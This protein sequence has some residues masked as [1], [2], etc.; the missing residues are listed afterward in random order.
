MCHRGLYHLLLSFTANLWKSCFTLL[1]PTPNHLKKSSCKKSKRVGP[2]QKARTES[3]IAL[4]VKG[5]KIHPKPITPKQNHHT[6]RFKKPKP[7]SPFS[8]AASKAQPRYLATSCRADG[9]RQRRP[10]RHHRW[11]G[12]AWSDRNI[13]FG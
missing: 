10:L 4:L 13:V 6:G 9:G 5:N 8:F 11:L 1:T 2:S 3:Y 12:N 7:Q